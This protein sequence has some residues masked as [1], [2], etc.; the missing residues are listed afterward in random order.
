MVALEIVMF[1]ILAGNLQEAEN[2]KEREN[3]HFQMMQRAVSYEAVKKTYY[4]YMADP[5]M[6]HRLKEIAYHKFCEETMEKFSTEDYYG[7]AE[8]LLKLQQEEFEADIRRPPE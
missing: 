7:Q 2:Y 5:E 6:A 4:F 1:L 3:I 8:T